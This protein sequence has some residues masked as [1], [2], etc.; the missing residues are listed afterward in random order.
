MWRKR[1]TRAFMTRISART[2]SS[3]QTQIRLRS[4]PKR[5]T[6][7]LGRV[8]HSMDFT[9]EADFMRFSARAMAR[10]NENKLRRRGPTDLS[11]IEVDGEYRLSPTSRIFSR[12]PPRISPWGPGA[13][14]IRR[15]R[16]CTHLHFW[17]CDLRVFRKDL[18]AR[19][20]LLPWASFLQRL[21]C[22]S[23]LVMRSR[24]IH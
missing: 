10:I 18:G 14:C 20:Y 7:A 21:S 19:R 22:F 13:V 11:S 16:I 6:C 17:F 4:H 9:N 5:N 8:P 1:I 23:R 24:C 2:E 15:Q 12:K 3:Q